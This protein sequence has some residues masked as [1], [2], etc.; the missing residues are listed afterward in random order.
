MSKINTSVWASPSRSS[1]Q[2][3]G[4]DAAPLN[5]AI[6]GLGY[7]GAVSAACLA[8]DGHRVIGV[9]PKASKVDLINQGRTPIVEKYVGE[10]IGEAVANETL[11]A[12]QDAAEAVAASDMSLICVGTPSRPNGSLDTSAVESVCEEIGAALKGETKPH[13]VVLRSTV[14]PGTMRSVVIPALQRASG[15]DASSGLFIAN[16]PEFLRESTAVHDYDEPPKTVIGAEDEE[17]ARRVAAI[18][19]HIEAPLF[20][21]SV[22]V[23][24]LVKYADNAWHAVKVVFGNEIGS[25]AKAVGVDSHDVMDIF[26]ADEKLNISPAYLRPGFA[27]GGSCLPK[28]LR[29]LIYRGKMLDVDMPLLTGAVVSNKRQIERAFDII[30]RDGRKNVAFLGISFKADTDDLRESPQ[31]ALVEQLLGKGY[32]VKIYD[33]NV[34]VARLTGANKDY[35]N[36]HIPHIANI[37]FDDFESVVE[38][39]D[40]VVIGNRAPEFRNVPAMLAPDQRLV[41]LVRIPIP[42][43]FTN[44][45]DGVNW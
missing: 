32:D 37:L 36:Q 38:S 11:R 30:T 7:V 44:E 1:S 17:T 2:G 28:D 42:D 39:G 27:F 43:N 4:I 41:D 26:C 14:L 8:R 20:L 19:E 15:R 16:N 3:A 29:A 35:V 33:R 31:V 40:I 6:F 22:D 12:T 25:I 45:Y 34:H 24:E 13:I 5:V 9:D 18:Y 21:T 10:L 23:A